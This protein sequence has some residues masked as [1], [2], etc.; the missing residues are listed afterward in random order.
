MPT[1][2]AL[3]SKTVWGAAL[4][5]LA[6]VFNF[7]GIEIGD[8]TP[9][10]TDQVLS[11][12]SIAGTVVAIYGRITATKEIA[13]KPVLPP[14]TKMFPIAA[15]ASG[16]LALQLLTSCE[17]MTPEQKAQ[18]ANLQSRAVAVGSTFVNA[19]AAYGAAIAQ[20]KIKPGNPYLDSVA[21]GLRKLQGTPLV[22][23]AQI[24]GI[25]TSF[26]D[27]NNPDPWQTLGTKVGDIVTNYGA[28]T[29]TNTGLET[30]SIA[31][32]QLN[33]AAVELQ[34]KAGTP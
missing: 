1:K 11:V 30:A 27:P 15:V 2:S 28:N 34:A 31:L 7:F 21:S 4:A 29:V 18:L 8:L 22:S 17:N 32:N 12:I 20:S 26:G 14:S 24:Q 5:G 16:A 3:Q 25:I 33:E 19:A 23:E 6:A 13:R 10:L 9:Q